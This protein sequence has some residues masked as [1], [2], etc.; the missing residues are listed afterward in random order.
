[1]VITLLGVIGEAA[2]LYL[3]YNNFLVQ[4]WCL[5]ILWF[6]YCGLIDIH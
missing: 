3:R 2:A 1:M 5:V 6:E 4:F